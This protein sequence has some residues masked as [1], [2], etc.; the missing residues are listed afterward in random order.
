MKAKRHIGMAFDG[1]CPVIARQKFDCVCQTE[2]VHE[3]LGDIANSD[4]PLYHK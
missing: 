1:V 3:I 2:R 4:V